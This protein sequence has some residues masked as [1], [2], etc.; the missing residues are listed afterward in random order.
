MIVDPE[1]DNKYQGVP[2]SSSVLIFP[3]HKDGSET[4]FQN[5]VSFLLQIKAM[6]KVN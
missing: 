6:V 1:C 2:H 5:V 3:L 4:N